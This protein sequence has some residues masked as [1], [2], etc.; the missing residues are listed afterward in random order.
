MLNP[1]SISVN[2]S[3]TQL[4]NALAG[5]D[6]E[7]A[8]A[9]ASAQATANVIENQITIQPLGLVWDGTNYIYSAVV[10]YSTTV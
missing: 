8:I 9:V 3:D 4:P 1:K 2:F 7:I 10:L 5:I 6:N